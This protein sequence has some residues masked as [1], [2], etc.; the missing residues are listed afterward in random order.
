MSVILYMAISSDGFIADE[1]GDTPW[2]D[3]EWAAFQVFV[4]SC[5]CVLVG[6]RAYEVMN[7]HND[8]VEGVEY[9]VVSEN[10]LFDAGG[11]PIINVKSKADLPEGER[12][13]V[14]GG[15]ELNGR[16]AKLGLLD[17]M[18]LDI[19]PVTLGSGIRLFGDYDIPLKLELLD[20]YEIG[21]ATIQRYYR[22]VH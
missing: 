17:E 9:I 22:V 5:D 12:I 13:G 18:I 7:D 10:P 4:E 19:E 3:E 15:G 2:S 21:E 20:S 14:I 16:L 8:F 1:D 6:R 11:F